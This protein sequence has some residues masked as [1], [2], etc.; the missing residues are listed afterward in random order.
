MIW[1]RLCW[2]LVGWLVVGL[3]SLAHGFVFRMHA[4]TGNWVGWV[5]FGGIDDEIR[6][7]Y[8]ILLCTH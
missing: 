8:I 1:F 3:G 4:L 6:N 5:G 2:A 7:L